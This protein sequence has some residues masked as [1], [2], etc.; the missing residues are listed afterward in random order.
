VDTPILDWGR[1]TVQQGNVI[2]MLDQ[3][4]ERTV[5]VPPQEKEGMTNDLGNAAP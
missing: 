1:D 5:P 2:R 3:D 4:G